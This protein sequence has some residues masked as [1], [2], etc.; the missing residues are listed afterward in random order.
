[1]LSSMCAW[2]VC[3]RAVDDTMLHRTTAS[4]CDAVDNLDR[5]HAIANVKL[6]AL[7]CEAIEL[8]FLSAGALTSFRQDG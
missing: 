5:L 1:M 2:N 6:K 3:E 8:S 4:L 7:R